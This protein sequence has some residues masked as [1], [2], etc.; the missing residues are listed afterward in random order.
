MPTLKTQKTI[1]MDPKKPK[2]KNHS[3]RF[4]PQTPCPVKKQQSFQ[5]PQ[6]FSKCEIGT[7]RNVNE[8][9]FSPKTK[10]KKTTQRPDASPST[11]S[12]K[13]ES[14]DSDACHCRRRRSPA[15]PVSLP[16]PSPDKETT[17][18]RNTI[19][20]TGNEEGNQRRCRARRQYWSSS[21]P[22]S[23]EPLGENRRK[24]V[25]GKLLAGN[26]C[27]PFNFFF[28]TLPIF[29]IVKMNF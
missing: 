5:P 7:T 14:Y 16:S 17:H 9:T 8:V 6:H 23:T 28:Q 18:H 19:A 24:I 29:F 20:A 25:A 3:P 13:K 2:P 27:M 12:P 26:H 11:P 4:E 10:T 21:L 1:N 22:S 15:T